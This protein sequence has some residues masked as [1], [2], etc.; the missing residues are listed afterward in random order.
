MEGEKVSTKVVVRVFFADIRPITIGYVAIEPHRVAEFTAKIQR[1]GGGAYSTEI[2]NTE[3]EEEI[4]KLVTDVH[5]IVT[6]PKE[7]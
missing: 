5:G 3:T 1:T 6:G 4:I 7:G 2:V